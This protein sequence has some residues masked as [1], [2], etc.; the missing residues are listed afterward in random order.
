MKLSF[1]LFLLAYIGMTVAADKPGKRR[2]GGE[3]NNRLIRGL[4]PLYE[5]ETCKTTK[6]SQVC[7]GSKSSTGILDVDFFYDDEYANKVCALHYLIN[8]VEDSGADVDSKEYMIGILNELDGAC[9]PCPI[10]VCGE[11]EDFCDFV[12]HSN[13]L[14]IC[15]SGV[16]TDCAE[17]VQAHCDTVSTIIATCPAGGYRRLLLENE[18]E[19]IE[20]DPT[21]ERALEIIQGIY[22]AD[23]E[24]TFSKEHNLISKQSCDALIH[25]MDMAVEK[26]KDRDDMPIG[27]AWEH[28]QEAWTPFDGGIDNQYNKKLYVDQLVKSIGVV[29]ALKLVDYFEEAFGEELTIDCLYLARHGNPNNELYHVPWHLDDY[30][31]MEITLNVNY[32]GG[33][34]LHLTKDGVQRTE[35]R[36]GTV[37]AHGTG[38]VHGITP[39]TNGAKYMLILKHHYNRE[40]K[41][42]VVRLSRDMIHEVVANE[43]AEEVFQIA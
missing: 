20:S 9:P 33:D 43:T 19:I 18:G 32:D 2:R 41:V 31:T 1:Q 37:T 15:N 39:N 42:G 23:P 35:A 38:I 21:P 5:Y 14:N 11:V 16:A 7:K 40:D 6:K 4:E 13:L 8:L 34:V 36:T 3:D 29:D 30:S 12:G 10:D 28:K 27:P 24:A 26:D 17:Q 22:G 25:Y